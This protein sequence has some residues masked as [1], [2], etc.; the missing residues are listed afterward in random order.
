MVEAIKMEDIKIKNGHDSK[1]RFVKGFVHNP[2]GN[3]QR[4]ELSGLIEALEV[5]AKREGYKNF[6]SLVADRAAQHETVLIAVLKKIY[7][8]QIEGK[9]FANDLRQYIIIRADSP[10]A[11]S[12]AG[13]V[14]I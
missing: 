9:G 8:D 1:G 14:R 4:K 3:T 11:Q 6:N 13:S 10:T 7:P 2:K 5:R 12:E